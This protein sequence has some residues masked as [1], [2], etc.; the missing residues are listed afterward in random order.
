MRRLLLQ[1]LVA[2]AMTAPAA[3][4]LPG[5]LGH[6][7]CAGAAGEHHAAV[8]VEHGNGVQRMPCVA[9][10]GDSINGYDLLVASGIENGTKDY[11]GS[12]G[13]AV[14]QVDNEPTTY[15]DSCFSSGG[16][17][18]AIFTSRHGGS[19][20]VSSH[21]VSTLSFADGDA[22]GFRYDDQGGSLP[23]PDRSASGL[24]PPPSTP[25]AAQTSPP[26]PTARPRATSAPGVPRDVSASST[27]TTEPQ[28]SAIPVPSGVAALVEPTTPPP[29][30][31]PSA[32]SPPVAFAAPAAAAGNA[33][34]LVS[35]SV[36][37]TVML[38]LLG[39]QIV[40]RQAG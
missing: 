19:W 16:R 28:A 20:Q 10:A 22:E 1:L 24:C 13:R 15:P 30:V 8:V 35:A 36:I 25:P 21:G 32:L 7:D 26:A 38:S 18:W 17:Y 14:C 4:I 6:V 12:L 27:A 2:A 33:G 34:G 29:G 39:W 40:R 37:A 11:G 5:G 31:S 3:V 23:A 9:F